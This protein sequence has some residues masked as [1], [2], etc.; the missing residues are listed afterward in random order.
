[1]FPAG[2]IANVDVGGSVGLS[3]ENGREKGCSGGPKLP[4]RRSGGVYFVAKV[5]AVGGKGF[6]LTEVVEDCEV[7]V[8]ARV[9]EVSEGPRGRSLF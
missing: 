8:S 6:R 5:E 9:L 1:V 3:R 2:E 4:E 7:I